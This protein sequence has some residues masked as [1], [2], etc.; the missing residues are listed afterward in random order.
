VAG[1]LPFPAAR[2][3]FAQVWPGFA[4]QGW[5]AEANAGG[6]L[7]HN[8]G[9]PSQNVDMQ[10]PEGHGI[11]MKWRGQGPLQKGFPGAPLPCPAI[12][13]QGSAPGLLY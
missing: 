8:L 6:A 7:L 5:S 13:E 11:L 10:L 1:R 4:E 9:V 3:D 12:A 2:P